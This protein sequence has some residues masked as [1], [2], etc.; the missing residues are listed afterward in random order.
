MKKFVVEDECIIDVGIFLGKDTKN[1]TKKIRTMLCN[2]E[3]KNLLMKHL[4]TYLYKG[5]CA[6]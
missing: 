3:E 5:R 2:Q 4:F 1:M 6:E